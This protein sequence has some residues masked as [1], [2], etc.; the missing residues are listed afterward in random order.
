MPRSRPR[1]RQ[2]D[3]KIVKIAVPAFA[4]LVAEPLMLLA[5][6]A[7]VGRL[8]TTPLAGLSV[9]STV[10]LTFVGLCVFLAYGTTA[11]VG[12][13][14]GAGDTRAALALGVDG[15]WL[16]LLIGVVAAAVASAASGPVIGLFGT[17]DAVAEQGVTYL[18][19]S[20]VGI[21]AM[22]VV[23]AAT[24]VL[25]GLQDLRTP[26]VV[27]IAANVVNA[28]LSV[29]LVHLVGLGI[30][31][32]AIGTVLA[33]VGAAAWLVAVV[34]RAARRHGAPLRPTRAG[35]AQAS[36]AGVAL[37]V[38]T[39][40]LRAALLLATFAAAA[41]GDASLAAQ[42][43]AVTVVSVVAYALDSIAIA[44]Q[45]LTGH[46]LGASDTDRARRLTR[47]MVGWGVLSGVVAAL[48][49]V[50]LHRALPGWFS[51]D[52]EVRAVLVPALLVVAVIQPVSGV[53]FVLDGVLIGAGDGV[54][55]A[56]AGVAT[57]V[58]YVPLVV[59]VWA[60]D[61]GLTWLWAAYGGFML[62]RMATLVL[63]ERS[64]RWLV[65]GATAHVPAP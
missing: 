20:A 25:R 1:F 44:G 53:V 57:L 10:L 37:V 52:D 6:T 38:R 21:P 49:V 9:A 54:Y 17:S 39:L 7:I 3:A 18:A 29:T 8:G 35:L 4:A 63:R 28:V 50:A 48:L 33:Q 42:Q 55:L 64:D 56:W 61:A 65:T 11:A 24:G 46:A 19:I 60:T 43:V 36:R 31:G 30:A 59:A 14:L 22:L 13:A 34:V 26:L 12:R 5:D 32:A 51:G 2:D 27:M 45:T 23:L 15:L 16:A 58:A 41:Q 47:R 40:T 62:A